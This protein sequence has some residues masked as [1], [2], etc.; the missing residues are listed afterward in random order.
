MSRSGRGRDDRAVAPTIG[1]AIPLPPSTTTLGGLSTARIDEVASAA[2]LELLVEVDFLAVPPPVTPARRGQLRSRA[3]VAGSRRRRRARSHRRARASRPCRPS[4]CARRCTSGRHRARASR[5]GN[6]GSRSPPGPHRARR[7]LP[8]ESLAI[9]RGK[10]GTQS[11]ACRGR[12]RHEAADRLARQL[13]E[14]A[15][16]GRDRS[17]SANLAVDLLRRRQGRGCN[18]P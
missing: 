17:A 9:A 11:G 3:D 18:M 15:G 10:L 16:E 2:A 7:R 12:A 4:G 13:A 8:P 14:H 1:P 6:R 5:P